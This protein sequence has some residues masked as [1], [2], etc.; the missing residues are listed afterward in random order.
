MDLSDIDIIGVGKYPVDHNLRLHGPPGTGKTTQLAARIAVLI[1]E[2]GYSIGDIAWVTYRRSLA[3]ETLERLV[4]WGVINDYQLKDPKEGATRFISTFHAVANRCAGA[5]SDPARSHHKRTFCEKMGLRYQSA[6]H[7]EQPA[8]RLLFRTFDWLV[9]NCY[10][11]GVEEHAAHCPYFMD[12][13]DQWAGGSVSDMWEKWQRFKKEGNLIDFNEMLTLALEREQT[14]GTPILVV[15]EYHDATPLMARLAEFWMEDASIVLVAADPAQ[16]VNAYDG[17]SPEFFKRLDYPKVLLDTTHRVS[18]R[19]WR[20]AGHVL[21]QSPSHSIPPVERVDDG[22]RIVEHNSPEFVRNGSRWDFPPPNITSSPADIIRSRDDERAGTLRDSKTTLFL[23][24][25]KGQV[26]GICRALEEAGII[27]QSQR[28]MDGWGSDRTKGLKERRRLYDV[29][30]ALDGYR[31]ESETRTRGGQQYLAQYEEI[32]GKTD[33]ALPST[34]LATFLEYVDWRHLAQSR[35]KTDTICAKLRGRTNAKL[36]RPEEIEGWVE[37]EFWQHYTRGAGSVS[38]LNKGAVT[39]RL[40][41]ALIKALK[42]NEHTLA[43]QR[44]PV[45]VMTI[46]ASKGYEADT[47]VLYDGISK[48][49]S[50]EMAQ[51]TQTLD[52][53]HRTWFVGLTR[54]SETLHIMRDGFE[55]CKSFLPTGLHDVT[56]AATVQQ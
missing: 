4:S 56:G 12:L 38:K 55:W 11:P 9:N 39:G 16:V 53:E 36:V 44:I 21:N 5:L 31:H 29:L 47:V 10:D 14:P 42:A 24:R 52:N 30:T 34:P 18:D 40:R 2:H 6:S 50:D 51:S 19:H 27:Y 45:S 32:D 54:A 17:A 8:G 33:L 3:M 22:G 25:T 7:W 35:S 13:K 23:A 41:N 26:D 49:I 46:H 28:R 1:L 43:S 20:A 48:R 15:D 37:P